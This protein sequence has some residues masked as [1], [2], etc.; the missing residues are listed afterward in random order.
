MIY[1]ITCKVHQV[2]VLESEL[3]SLNIKLDDI[4]NQLNGKI[5]ES[6]KHTIPNTLTLPVVENNSVGSGSNSIQSGSAGYGSISNC[7]NSERDCESLDN[8]EAIG[9]EHREYV[10]SDHFLI[11]ATIRLRPRKVAK[12]TQ[13]RK[14]LDVA[15]LKYPKTIWS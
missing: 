4:N 3:H 12:Q 10:N 9:E 6:P 2:Q 8:S 1:P 11:K 14:H 5:G 15:K 13:S 7:S